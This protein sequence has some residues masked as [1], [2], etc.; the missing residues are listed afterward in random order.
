MLSTISK[1]KMLPVFKQLLI[2]W[3]EEESSLHPSLSMFPDEDID[4]FYKK[5]EKSFWV[6]EEVLPDLAKDP[7]DWIKLSAN[8]QL[9]VKNVLAFF[10]ISDFYVNQTIG[11]QVKPRIK[12]LPW[13]RWED[14]KMMIEN[15]HNFTYGKLAECYIKDKKERKEILDAV[16][17]NPAIQQKVNWMHKWVGK[18]NELAHID[19]TK[20]EAIRELYNTYIVE[21]IRSLEQLGMLTPDMPL[22][23]Q[24][25]VIN[26]YVPAN[27]RA[28]GDELMTEKASLALV[29]LINAIAEGVFFSGS[30][31]AIFW[32]KRMGL[33]PGLSFANDLI[34]RDEGLH[35]MFA[36]MVYRC[37]LK[38]QLP[39]DLVHEIMR[40]AVDIERTFIC[41]S[42]PQDMLGMN[43]NLMGKY[44]EFV[45]DQQLV[46]LGYERIW[47][48]SDQD[49]P[50]PWMESQSHGIRIAD[51]F[52]IRPNAYGHHASALTE[53]EMKPSFDEDF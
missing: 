24:N 13:H 48:K 4:F 15:T 20:R 21:K 34:S 47:T 31:C 14:F 10:A 50:F 36:I 7:Q 25:E 1:R 6:F 18:S 9:F 27:V 35:C 45:A 43:A 29:V 30:F 19:Q 39:Q 3:V 42:L 5:A 12:F 32:F 41:N 51:F 28:L 22:D 33:L 8:Q 53:D 52:K 11:E 26:K 2:E 46:N 49:N 16:R 40:E 37:K 23:K 44:I 17:F 38:H